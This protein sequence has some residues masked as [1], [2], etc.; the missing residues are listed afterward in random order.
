M[1]RNASGIGVDEWH[2]SGNSARSPS[3]KPPLNSGV[4]DVAAAVRDHPL[5]RLS[6]VGPIQ[7]TAEPRRTPVQG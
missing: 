5:A 4:G 3:E 1:V 2:I 6:P 7:S